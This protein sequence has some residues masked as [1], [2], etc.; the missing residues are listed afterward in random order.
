MN[1][2][3]I[4]AGTYFI[5]GQI[6]GKT[7]IEKALKDYLQKEEV[8]KSFDLTTFNPM[9]QYNNYVILKEYPVEGFIKLQYSCLAM[10]DIV[11]TLPGWDECPNAKS[12]VSIAR[13]MGKEILAYSTIILKYTKPG[14]N[15]N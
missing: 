8:L 6:N 9:Q 3:E 14:S 4:F 13:I 1:P 5:I 10:C 11:V 15:G 2:L 12:I 7:E